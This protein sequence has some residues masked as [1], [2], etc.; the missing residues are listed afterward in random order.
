MCVDFRKL[1][2]FTEN[3]SSILEKQKINE[4]K[5]QIFP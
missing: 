2:K 4:K 1:E 3:R 5:K